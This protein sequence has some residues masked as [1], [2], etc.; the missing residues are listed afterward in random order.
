MFIALVGVDLLL[1]VVN[2]SI[3]SDS[4]TPAVL[5]P[6]DDQGLTSTGV[7]SWRSFSLLYVLDVAEI[8]LLGASAEASAAAVFLGTAGVDSLEETGSSSLDVG[9]SASFDVGK[10]ERLDRLDPCAG[11]SGAQAVRESELLLLMPSMECGDLR[12]ILVSD[13]P[14]CR[15]RCQ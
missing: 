7:G 3:S 4:V 5:D 10:F 2:A 11:T 6:S 9:E 1:T 15:R 14:V 12:G 8:V 13:A